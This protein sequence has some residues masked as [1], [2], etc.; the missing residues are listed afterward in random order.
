MWAQPNFDELVALLKDVERYR[1]TYR[2]EARESARRIRGLYS[3]E[4][5]ARG[6][7]EVW[8]GIGN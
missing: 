6:V 4:K 5:F 1:E 7:I 3:W 8:K 2:E